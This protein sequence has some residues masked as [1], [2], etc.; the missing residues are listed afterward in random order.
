MAL[1]TM[2]EH[3]VETLEQFKEDGNMDDAA[4]RIMALLQ[5]VYDTGYKNG[6]EGISS[7][8]TSSKHRDA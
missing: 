7:G 5:T 6:G 3:V 8:L 2:A 1:L 4:H